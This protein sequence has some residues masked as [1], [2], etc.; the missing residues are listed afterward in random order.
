[1]IKFLRG[2]PGIAAD[3]QGDAP[4]PGRA[5]VCSTALPI[6]IFRGYLARQRLGVSA[7]QP[8]ELEMVPRSLN[9]KGFWGVETT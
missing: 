7:E 9:I 2:A 6:E 8:H 3:K 4:W 1:L 5:R